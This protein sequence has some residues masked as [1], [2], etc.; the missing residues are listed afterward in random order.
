M[1]QH[2]P[3]VVSSDEIV[4]RFVFSPIHVHKKT[5]A[6]LPSLFSHAERQGCSVQRDSRADPAELAAFASSFLKSNPKATWLGVV[7]A[8][9]A[10][11]RAIALDGE[12]RRT[13]CIYDTAEKKNPAHA[14][15]FW[16]TQALQE[17]DAGELRK[18]LLDAFNAS[19]PMPP[20]TYR[21]GAVLNKI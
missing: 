1:S 18:H 17:G 10:D 13:T 20:S 2:S 7:L 12:T 21:S 19:S 15:I 14:E 5:G 4:A 6:I 3:G 8:K 11:V 16:T 9:S